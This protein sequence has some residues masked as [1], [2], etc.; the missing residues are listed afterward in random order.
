MG[1]SMGFETAF[2]MGFHTVAM[3]F[4]VLEKGQKKRA[5][6]SA[7]SSFLHSSVLFPRCV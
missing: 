6:L 5:R 3:W 1:F 4:K 2:E 7:Y